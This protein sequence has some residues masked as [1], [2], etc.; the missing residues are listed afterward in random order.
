MYS[1]YTYIYVKDDLWCMYLLHVRIYYIIIYVSIS[2]YKT[3]IKCMYNAYI[4]HNIE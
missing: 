2:Y 1:L 4:K 3:N